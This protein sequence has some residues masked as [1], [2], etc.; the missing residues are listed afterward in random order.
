M[1][2]E[3]GENVILTPPL[4][5]KLGYK[6]ILCCIG[7]FSVTCR[8]YFLIFKCGFDMF[9]CRHLII[10]SSSCSFTCNSRT[11]IRHTYT[12]KHGLRSFLDISYIWVHLIWKTGHISD[13]PTYLCVMEVPCQYRARTLVQRA[14]CSTGQLYNGL[15]DKCPVGQIS[16]WTPPGWGRGLVPPPF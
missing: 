4:Q 11:I 15:L 10:T 3:E 14:S 1:W 7:G 12:T 13:I 16:P 2:W 5:C 9:K 6:I 8:Y